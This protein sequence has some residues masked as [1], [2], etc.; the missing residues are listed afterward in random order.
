MNTKVCAVDVTTALLA[1][2]KLRLL[3]LVF[4]DVN[5]GDSIVA[6]S[7]SDGRVLPRISQQFG[8]GSCLIISC[9]L[10]QRI[11]KRCA[12]C[13]IAVIVGSGGDCSRKCL[14]RLVRRFPRIA[15]RGVR[16]ERS[17]L[18]FHRVFPVTR[19]RILLILPK[20]RTFLSTSYLRVNFPRELRGL[21]ISIRRAFIRRT[22]SGVS[23]TAILAGDRLTRLLRIMVMPVNSPSIVGRPA[24]IN[25]AILRVPHRREGNVLFKLSNDGRDAIHDL[26]RTSGLGRTCALPVRPLPRAKRLRRVEIN[27]IHF[28]KTEDVCH[29]TSVTRRRRKD[30]Q[31]LY[32][33]TLNRTNGYHEQRLLLR[34]TPSTAK[35]LLVNCR[36][37]CFVMRR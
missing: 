1:L 13:R 23:F 4:G 32:R 22:N 16:W 3:D 20:V 15:I 10:S 9:G 33:P 5:V 31:F 7:A 24:L 14:L 29:L 18:F 30:F 37:G 34:S 17:L 26:L 25:G 19:K 8:S 2:T 11:R 6:F 35:L 28:G 21:F 12:G 36:Y 27:G